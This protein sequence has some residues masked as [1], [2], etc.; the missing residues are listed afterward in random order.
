M[1]RIKQPLIFLMALMLGCS[2]FGAAWGASEPY[3]IFADGSYTILPTSGSK[4][5]K[6][7]K[8]QSDR[9]DNYEK[10]I[11]DAAVA[12]VVSDYWRNRVLMLFGK[13]RSDQVSGYVA[14]SLD[15]DMKIVGTIDL[16][17]TNGM[18]ALMFS[19]DGSLSYLS[20]F[21][22]NVQLTAIYDG[23]NYIKRSEEK[24]GQLFVNSSSCFLGNGKI[25]TNGRIVDLKTSK[26]V[27]PGPF[28]G[29]PYMQM[30][31][32]NGRVLFLSDENQSANSRDLK[33]VITL[34]D[35]GKD[36][37]LGVI[38]TGMSMTGFRSAEWYLSK[39]G[40]YVIRDEYVD[41]SH[42]GVRMSRKTGVLHFFDITAGKKTGEIRLPVKDNGIDSKVL[43]F[44]KS[45]DKWAYRLSRTL[46]IIDMKQLKLEKEIEFKETDFPFLPVG[47][48]WPD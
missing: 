21:R 3:I 28:Q 41:D 13:V 42:N 45:G 12:E 43:G 2:L 25:F 17:N 29:K 37:V 4:I 47:I 32:E 6:I 10:I 18:P 26:A 36:A 30:S 8:F 38:K 40:R 20:Y 15:K 34:Y 9:N 39:D 5:Q 16:Q 14:A 23:E 27:R 19:S 46:F 11:V 35:S 24:T 48:Y 22:E 33:A 7:G 44:S 1:H 31:C